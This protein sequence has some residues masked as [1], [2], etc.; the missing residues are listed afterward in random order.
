MEWTELGP[1]DRLTYLIGDIARWDAFL[2]IESGRVFQIATTAGTPP[3]KP[4]GDL[5]HLLDDTK[6][7]LRGVDLDAFPRQMTRDAIGAA[8][9]AHGQRVGPVHDYWMHHGGE[10][11]RWTRIQPLTTRK[12]EVQ[13]TPHNLSTFL[14]ARDDLVHAGWRMRG[15]W[16]VLPM[17]LGL[18]SSLDDLG[19][20]AVRMWTT[21]ALGKFKAPAG[22]GLTGVEPDPAAPLP[23]KRG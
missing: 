3:Q 16:L 7:A 9:A 10:H 14:K 6:D 22:Y 8:K 4:P 23:P 2:E 11:E 13:A 1:D 18:P 15:V 12:P 21:V 19:E 5:A 17:W 20:D